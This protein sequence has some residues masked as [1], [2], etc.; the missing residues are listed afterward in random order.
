MIPYMI[1]YNWLYNYQYKEGIKNV[2][3]GMNRRTN[4]KGQIDLAIEDLY[5][6]DKGTFPTKNEGLTILI[7]TE[8]SSLGYLADLPQDPWGNK[9]E[10][11][12]KATGGIQIRSSGQDGIFETSNIGDD[13]YSKVFK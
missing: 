13:H 7:N 11:V 6:L 2:L 4:N 1:K 9:Y 5:K 8:N 3:Q 10:M 12:F